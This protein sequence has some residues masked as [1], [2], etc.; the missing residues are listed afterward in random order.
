MKK[1]KDTAKI[2][3]SKGQTQA[4]RSISERL[5]YSLYYGFIVLFP[6]AM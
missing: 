4:V 6:A 2:F 1:M 3:N 5:T